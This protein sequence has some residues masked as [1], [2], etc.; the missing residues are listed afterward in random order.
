MIDRYLINHIEDQMYEAKHGYINCKE[1]IKMLVIEAEKERRLYIE[2][3]KRLKRLLGDEN[4][5]Q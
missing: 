3:K 5:H 2:K 1:L 4:G